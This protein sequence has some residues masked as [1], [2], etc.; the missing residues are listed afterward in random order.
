MERRVGILPV[1]VLVLLVVVLG[2]GAV[3]Y[4]AGNHLGD[5]MGQPLRD[6]ESAS[7]P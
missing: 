4:L 1:P 2:F 3:L 5:V 6:L 7:S